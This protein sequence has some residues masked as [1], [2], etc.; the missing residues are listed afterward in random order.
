MRD[1]AVIGWGRPGEKRISF[2]KLIRAELA[3]G[4]ADAKARFEK[5]LDE[6]RPVVIPAA[7][8]RSFDLAR[9]VWGLGGEVRVLSGHAN[10]SVRGLAAN[11]ELSDIQSQLDD[12]DE[13]VARRDWL[14]AIES[15]RPDLAI[16]P[17][18][19]RKRLRGYE[20]ARAA[21]RAIGSCELKSQPT[22]DWTGEL[23]LP[24]PLAEYY[25]DFGPMDLTLK[26]YGNPYFLPALEN[27]WAH[28]RGYRWTVSSSGSALDRPRHENWDDDWLVVA[29][30]GGDPFILSRSTGRVLRADHGRGSWEPGEIFESV[31]QMAAVLTA[32]GSVCA[33]AGMDLTGDDCFIR[34]RWRAFLEADL[35]DA[36]GSSGGA[37]MLAVLGFG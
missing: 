32:I 30:E 36:L 22:T 6:G 21:C 23:A 1:V 24:A 12:I 27:L 33:S 4:L 26:A 7:T 5:L 17:E 19:T 3:V 11:D 31:E 13:R 9:E 8:P 10:A 37:D 25:R 15:V 34:P 2:I 16:G 29:D 28:Q 18:E 35:D 14:S 20:L